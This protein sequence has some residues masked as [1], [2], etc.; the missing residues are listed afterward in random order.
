ML[1][2]TVKEVSD[3]TSMEQ[4]MRRILLTSANTEDDNMKVAITTPESIS[5]KFHE[6]DDIEEYISSMKEEHPYLRL[7]KYDMWTLR[8]NKP[9]YQ[10]NEYALLKVS[11][12]ELEEIRKILNPNL[13][14]FQIKGKNSSVEGYVDL[15]KET[16]RF[17]SDDGFLEDMFDFK[18]K[19]EDKNELVRVCK[20]HR[21]NLRYLLFEKELHD[22]PFGELLGWGIKDSQIDLI[23]KLDK[24]FLI[25]M[26]KKDYLSKNDECFKAFIDEHIHN[27]NEYEIFL[28]NGCIFKVNFI[29]KHGEIIKFKYYGNEVVVKSQD[30]N[31][32]NI[33]KR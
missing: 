19:N 8:W 27:N 9:R 14:K 4:H 16:I 23:G 7:C 5:S 10:C 25:S 1:V 21:T 32:M 20:T 18:S 30:L 29:E 22:I 3:S 13:K 2:N 17:L 26:D 31:L 15:E 6:V 24:H 12:D 11:W 33:I 28:V